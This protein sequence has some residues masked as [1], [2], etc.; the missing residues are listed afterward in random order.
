MVFSSWSNLEDLSLA[1]IIYLKFSVL[2][3]KKLRRIFL[4]KKNKTL[5]NVTVRTH[6]GNSTVS[7]LL[8]G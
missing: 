1:S 5:R 6:E 7:D 2:G 4:G 8:R 3:Y